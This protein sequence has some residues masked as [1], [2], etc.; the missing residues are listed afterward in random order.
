MSKK[1]P[2]HKLIHRPFYERLRQGAR[3]DHE[4]I[5]VIF[6]TL[7]EDLDGEEC[8]QFAAM[9]IGEED[10]FVEGTYVP[11]I[12]FVLRKVLPDAEDQAGE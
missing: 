1:K 12:W 4:N 5:E 2:K 9:F 3:F 7:A 6:E 11:E 10:E 8:G